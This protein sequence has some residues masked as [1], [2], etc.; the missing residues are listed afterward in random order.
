MCICLAIAN[1]QDP[2][3]KPGNPI[4]GIIVKGG[5]NPGGHMVISLGGGFINPSSALKAKANMNNGIGFN[6][7]IYLPVFGSA[8]NSFTLGPT[9][10]FGYGSSN[11]SNDLNKYH[12]YN[13]DGQSNSPVVGMKN[14]GTPKQS[15]IKYE[16]GLQASF[17]YGAIVILPV[18][19]AASISTKQ[20]A[21]TV[22]QTSTVNGKTTSYD[23]ISTG[24]N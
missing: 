18:I 9:V 11:S 17:S 4:G 24:K 14:M 13:I 19:A 10:S 6:A 21:F 23:F 20:A 12:P 5:K 15:E 16:A 8:D 2:S 1:A 7:G 3:N 22:N